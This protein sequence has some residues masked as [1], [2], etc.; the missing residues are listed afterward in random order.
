MKY[1][2]AYGRSVIDFYHEQGRLV[3]A[4]RSLT[5]VKGAF[6]G[7][8]SAFSERDGIPPFAKAAKD[9][10]PTGWFVKDE[11]RA[12]SRLLFISA[13]ESP[14]FAGKPKRL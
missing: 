9:G 11:G 14:N 12:V 8:Q 4:Q 10:A 6:S 5:Q 13:T 7:R 1:E 3:R 2:A